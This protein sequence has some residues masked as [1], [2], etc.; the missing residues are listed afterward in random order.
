MNI[1]ADKLNTVQSPERQVQKEQ[2]MAQT[3]ERAGQVVKHNPEA[4]KQQVSNMTT[5]FNNSLE[6]L[7]VARQ[8]KQADHESIKDRKLGKKKAP[9]IMDAAM[10]QTVEHE[11][12]PKDP[13]DIE[14]YFAL[15]SMLNNMPDASADQ[16]LAFIKEQFSNQEEPHEDKEHAFLNFAQKTLESEGPAS[17]ERAKLLKDS[18]EKLEAQA[19][20]TIYKGYQV[21]SAAALAEELGWGAAA[22]FKREYIQA[23]DSVQ[24]PGELL[25]KILNTNSSQEAG[26]KLALFAQAS[27]TEVAGIGNFPAREELENK[28]KTMGDLRIL[29]Q[30]G[31]RMQTLLDNTA[32]QAALQGIKLSGTLFSGGSPKPSRI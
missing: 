10:A 12:K 1:Q 9:V 30:G 6:E 3:G 14:R 16:V 7:S 24:G 15:M 27:Q 22:D 21:S 11:H 25:M 20:P 23:V 19:G 8:E 18:K 17:Q 5:L 29:L 4:A 2:N 26:R 31:E 28:L 32:R 13:D